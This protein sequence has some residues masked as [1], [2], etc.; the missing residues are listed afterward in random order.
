[1]FI[2]MHSFIKIF[3]IKE[4]DFLCY[5][6]ISKTKTKIE[7][8]IISKESKSCVACLK[9]IAK[10]P[11]EFEDNYN[12]LRNFYI[13][14]YNSYDSD[15]YQNFEKTDE[16]NN[17]IKDLKTKFDSIL[18]NEV[19]KDNIGSTITCDKCHEYEEKLK[20]A[21]VESKKKYK[22]SDEYD[23]VKDFYSHWI[24][25]A[26]YIDSIINNN[27]PLIGIDILNNLPDNLKQE[28]FDKAIE[29]LCSS[30]LNNRDKTQELHI[31]FDD[32]EFV[33]KLKDVKIDEK[34]FNIFI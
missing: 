11:K 4:S 9:L 25:I 6:D 16:T 29:N 8:F 21:K 33:S 28:H 26:S 10:T 34:V 32:N 2:H 12:S 20:A 30:H 19:T 18:N 1:M 15:D 17:I 7:T 14:I 31:K 22:N 5:D 23:D 27:S 24:L 13:D 3:V